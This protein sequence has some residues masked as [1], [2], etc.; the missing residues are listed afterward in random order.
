MMDVFDKVKRSEVMSHIRGKG[1]KKTE[2]ALLNLF[3]THRITGW[4]RSQTVFGKPDFVFRKAHVVVFVD[5]CFWHV[6]PKHGQFP[7]TN[8]DF[9][10]RKL[11]ANIKRDHIVTRT[12]KRKGWKV[13]RIWEC[14]LEIRS[15]RIVN[16]IRKA[17]G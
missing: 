2:I 12:L 5:G 7:I 11:E 10:R 6:C 16:T 1:N 3:K 8:R 13:I 9:W 14:Q 17:I 4:R 15:R